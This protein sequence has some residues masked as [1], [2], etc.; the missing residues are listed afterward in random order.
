MEPRYEHHFVVSAYTNKDNTIAFKIVQNVT[1]P[2]NG[3]V[4][5]DNEV[6]SWVSPSVT[7]EVHSNDQRM[8]RTLGALLDAIQLMND[9]T[10]VDYF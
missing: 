7:T 3:R 6:G 10:T 1:P 8:Y 5:F 4:V 2:S 9:T